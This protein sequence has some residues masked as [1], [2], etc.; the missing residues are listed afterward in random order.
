[1]NIFQAI[2]ALEVVKHKLTMSHIVQEEMMKQQEQQR[3]QSGIVAA[4]PNLNIDPRQ[5]R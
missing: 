2:Y 5:L 4:R 1:M 3:Q